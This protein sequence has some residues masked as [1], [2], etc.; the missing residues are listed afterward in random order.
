MN[1]RKYQHGEHFL[2]S[3][4][5]KMATPG[6]NRLRQ[7]VFHSL[8]YIKQSNYNSDVDTDCINMHTPH[9]YVTKIGLYFACPNIQENMFKVMYYS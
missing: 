9:H 2:S 7:I 4:V 6:C 8:Y 1:G 5:S 3:L